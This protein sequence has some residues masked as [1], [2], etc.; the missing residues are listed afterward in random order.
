MRFAEAASG[1]VEEGLTGSDRGK[2]VTAACELFNGEQFVFYDAAEGFHVALTCA[3]G[4][5]VWSECH[6]GWRGGP[7]NY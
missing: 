7:E 5:R 1:I 4:R 6:V 2:E 3:T